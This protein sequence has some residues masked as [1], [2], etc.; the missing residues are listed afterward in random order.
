MADN[1]VSFDL[2]AN[3]LEDISNLKSVAIQKLRS[4]PHVFYDRKL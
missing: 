4:R 2:V 3:F 1:E